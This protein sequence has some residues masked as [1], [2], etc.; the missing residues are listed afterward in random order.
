MN[1]K[2]ML[3]L[4]FALFFFIFC[5]YAL[6]IQDMENVELLTS[7][8]I[9]RSWMKLLS[10]R[11]RMGHPP[12][13]FLLSKLLMI[14]LD[15]N[16]VS[17]YIFPI[18]IGATGIPLIYFLGREQGLGQGSLLASFF[19]SIHPA[20]LYY[21]RYIRPQIGIVVLC[22]LYLLVLLRNLEKPKITNKF[23]LL[24]L[25][26]AG[27]LWSHL[28][29]FFW[30]SILFA[31]LLIRKVRKYA[32]KEYWLMIVLA[33]FSQVA[34]TGIVRVFSGSIKERL[35]WVKLPTFYDVYKILI[36]ALGAVTGNIHVA[37]LLWLTPFLGLLSFF[38]VLY[39]NNVKKQDASKQEPYRSKTDGTSCLSVH[40]CLVLSFLR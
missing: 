3:L 35:E 26:M 21:S 7:E 17:L 29:L 32:S 12:L 13:Y 33:L 39:F 40:C 30:L 10:N 24:S 31:S 15:H 25:G 36:Q 23:L 19:W 14:S 18:V 38:I 2:I 8:S 11:L 22:T 16:L 37:G 5:F 1:N 20:V 27:A 28:F 34:V 4:A 6:E 9:R